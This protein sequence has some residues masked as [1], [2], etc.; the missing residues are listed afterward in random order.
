MTQVGVRHVQWLEAMPWE[1]SEEVWE[2]VS[3]PRRGPVRPRW[4]SLTVQ[5]NHRRSL[6]HSVVKPYMYFER[7]EHH[8]TNLPYPCYPEEMVDSS[9]TQGIISPQQSG[10]RHGIASYLDNDVQLATHHGLAKALK[11][12]SHQNFSGNIHICHWKQLREPS[13]HW[14]SWIAEFPKSFPYTQEEGWIYS[15]NSFIPP[16]VGKDPAGP[17]YEREGP[18][19]NFFTEFTKTCAT[20]ARVPNKDNGRVW[21]LHQST[22]IDKRKKPDLVL[23]D[24]QFQ[25]FAEKWEHV[26]SICQ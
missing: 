15:S 3:E 16:K 5:H 10:V 8:A 7:Q 20:V 22:Y 13:V 18:F 12:E 26:R 9:G 19:A 6:L 14:E 17:E 1:T 4:G 25:T 11:R 2:T 24:S 23:L 21:C